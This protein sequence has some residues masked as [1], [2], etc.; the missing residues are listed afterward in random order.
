MYKYTLHINIYKYKYIYI[1]FFQ[2]LPEI[3]SSN[4]YGFPQFNKYR[5]V[6]IVKLWLLT[7]NDY[8]LNIYH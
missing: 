8:I 4:K 1:F 3:P 6:T 5:Q 2:I 7:L